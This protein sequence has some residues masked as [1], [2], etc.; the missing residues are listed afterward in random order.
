M[1]HMC[2]FLFWVCS[3]FT[4]CVHASIWADEDQF[5]LFCKEVAA[6]HNGI[7]SLPK[8]ETPCH[9]AYKI[10]L[11]HSTRKAKARTVFDNLDHFY[12]VFSHLPDYQ[13]RGIAQTKVALDNP[14]LHIYTNPFSPDYRER[15]TRYFTDLLLNSH[16]KTREIKRLNIYFS[17]P[18]DF[19]QQ[20]IDELS[21]VLKALSSLRSYL[22]P[23]F[24]SQYLG[25]FRL[26]F[27]IDFEGGFSASSFENLGKLVSQ[28]TCD[29]ALDL[30]CALVKQ[31]FESLAQRELDKHSALSRTESAVR[32]FFEKVSLSEGQVS[33]EF[34]YAGPRHFSKGDLGTRVEFSFEFP[35]FRFTRNV[36]P[37]SERLFLSFYS[38]ILPGILQSLLISRGFSVLE[39]VYSSTLPELDVS[40]LGIIESPD[41]KKEAAHEEKKFSFQL[42]MGGEEEKWHKEYRKSLLSDILGVMWRLRHLSDQYGEDFSAGRGSFTLIDPGHKLYAFLMQYVRFVTGSSNPRELP[43]LLTSTGFAYR[44]DPK[45]GGSSHHVTHSTDAQFGIDIRL[46]EGESIL[47]YLPHKCAHIL[48]G[49]LDNPSTK[50]KEPLTFIKWE[51]VGLGSFTEAVSH[52]VNFVSPL[53]RKFS[54]T[55]LVEEE[56]SLKRNEKKIHPDIQSL[57]S[58]IG[59]FF[60]SDDLSKMELHEI[61]QRL[62]H[63]P[64]SNPTQARIFEQFKERLDHIHPDGHHHIRFGNEIIL[65]LGAPAPLRETQRLSRAEEASTTLT[66]GNF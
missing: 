35:F 3:V 32:K 65:D 52:G 21:D 14:A 38:D 55:S 57:F 60:D 25:A 41:L 8:K 12:E 46:E 37:N 16:L 56:S 39:K 47:R 2:L 61:Y 11:R 53:L 23:E 29:P 28:H 18:Q 48:F 40:I 20:S 1:Q 9:P 64:T 5:D 19:H 51:T 36:D 42:I 54:S 50:S 15:R 31:T 66:R 63:N 34:V 22:D 10:K 45:W 7:N 4:G 58:D 59:Q 27:F 13:R 44:R 33:D 49:K 26:K 30:S 62:E 24:I 17:S 6:Q 43:Y